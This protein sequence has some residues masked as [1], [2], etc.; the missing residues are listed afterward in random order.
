MMLQPYRN[1]LCLCDWLCM[2]Q[3]RLVAIDLAGLDKYQDS[4][5]WEKN[6]FSS[7]FFEKI[8]PCYRTLN[9]GL[10]A[11]LSSRFTVLAPNYRIPLVHSNGSAFCLFVCFFLKY[12]QLWHLLSLVWRLS[13]WYDLWDLKLQE[14]KSLKSYF[15]DRV[16]F[17]EEQYAEKS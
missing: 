2:L 9:A 10:C 1:T 8:T 6:T 12:F 5:Y 13:Q 11:L 7:G 16:C 3:R 15:C 4:K 14:F 17:T